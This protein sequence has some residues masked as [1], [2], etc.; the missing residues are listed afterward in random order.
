MQK[1]DLTLTPY[2][3][4][5]A[6]PHTYSCI[7]TELVRFFSCK[8]SQEQALISCWWCA[9]RLYEK[10]W[11]LLW[12]CSHGFG[13]S[14]TILCQVIYS[15]HPGIFLYLNHLGQSMFLI[16]LLYSV[17]CNRTWLT[18]VIKI[19]NKPPNLC[20]KMMCILSVFHYKIWFAFKYR[21]L[22]YF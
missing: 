21:Q 20:P 18:S 7:T 16:V 22:P 17:F 10:C 1:A 11:T 4:T 12:L 19:S 2:P 9:R 3:F 8:N 6:P 5:W 15:P 14:P 13:T